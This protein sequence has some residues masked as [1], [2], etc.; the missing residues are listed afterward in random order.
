MSLFLKKKMI[1]R[2][3]MKKL[4]ILIAAVMLM[5]FSVVPAFALS[6]DSPVATTE[7]ETEPVT[8]VPKPDDG[9]KSPKTGENN[10]QV[11]LLIGISALGCGLAAYALAKSAKRE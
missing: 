3:A 7:P 8:D 5:A 4:I 9:G 11:F 1:R 2:L 6:V 10:A